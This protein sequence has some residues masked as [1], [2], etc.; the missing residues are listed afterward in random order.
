MEG[1]KL[2][3]FAVP[4]V[5]ET[6]RGLAES[7]RAEVDCFKGE[8]LRGVD[9]M[10]ELFPVP[11]ATAS[12]RA[13]LGVP[14]EPLLAFVA[15][16]ASSLVLP[17]LPEPEPEATG[18]GLT[19]GKCTGVDVRELPI[20]SALAKYEVMDDWRPALDD[21]E[22]EGAELCRRERS[23]AISIRFADLQLVAHL[24]PAILVLSVKQTHSRRAG[25]LA[26]KRRT[27]FLG[28]GEAWAPKHSFC[29]QVIISTA[30]LY[31][32]HPT[33][34]A[35]RVGDDVILKR[36]PARSPFSLLPHRS[37]F[38]RCLASTFALSHSSRATWPPP[39]LPTTSPSSPSSTVARSQ[40]SDG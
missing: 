10:G 30:P 31:S 22:E 39:S 18:A 40:S 29:Y 3:T 15:F 4:S 33:S 28:D 1:T 9:L 16:D 11:L 21:D 38:Q 19:G 7:E 34:V 35:R 8:L 5:N 36:S 6:L 20:G 2:L 14:G 23:L 37:A 25:C 26:S 12:L 13:A 24:A 17:F 32:A 27:P